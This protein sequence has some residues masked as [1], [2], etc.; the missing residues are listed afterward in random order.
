MRELEEVI[1]PLFFHHPRQKIEVRLPVLRAILALLEVTL[2]LIADVEAGQDLLQYIRDRDVLENP[3]LKLP[4]QLPDIG[5]HAHTVRGEFLVADPLH[6]LD[7]DAV[8]IPC[9]Q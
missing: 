1:N 6:E 8:E 4:G 5:R 9:N 7:H 2:D 3:A